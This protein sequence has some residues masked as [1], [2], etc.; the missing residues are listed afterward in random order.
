MYRI[1]IMK[2]TILALTVTGLFS[3]NALSAPS[4]LS[5]FDKI[6]NNPEWGVP[7]QSMYVE[8]NT[9]NYFFLDDIDNKYYP[10]TQNGV[11]KHRP[12]RDAAGLVQY[13][14]QS[15]SIRD[16]KK[17]ASGIRAN[18]KFASAQGKLISLSTNTLLDENT[19]QTKEINGIKSRGEELSEHVKTLTQ[20]HSNL[21]IKV[22]AYSTRVD[23]VLRTKQGEQ[24]IQGEQ[25]KQGIQGEQGIQGIQG[26]RGLTGNRGEQ[27]EQGIQGIAGIQGEK[28]ETGEKGDAFKFSDFTPNDLELLKGGPEGIQGEQGEQG[29]QGER[30]FDGRDGLEISTEYS[31]QVN[32]NGKDD[33]DG[34]KWVIDDEKIK[35]ETNDEASAVS[36]ADI[37]VKDA[38]K[39]LNGI[40]DAE[41]TKEALLAASQNLDK[42]KE[43][44]RAES[45]ALSDKKSELTQR[46]KTEINVQKHIVGKD[47]NKAGN[48]ANGINRNESNIYNNRK[49][50]SG[51][52]TA[53]GKN[54]TAIGKNTTAIGKNTTDI[55]NLR[56]DF[57]RLSKDYYSFKEQTNGAIAGVAAMGQLA[58]PYGVGN[59]SFGAAVGNYNS[60]QA[61]AV[62]M[63]YRYSENVTVRAAAAANSGNNM[64]PILAASIN[65]EW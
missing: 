64:E 61:I 17:L 27:G 24:G 39:A 40:K 65:Y 50:I 30:G 59:F 52:T 33:K 36:E 31:K 19:K 4:D 55:K 7:Y 3:A 28:G 47:D 54:T 25:G 8:E 16:I 60:E 43:R 53:I 34:K 29:I 38:E 62:G 21:D 15:A 37:A 58:Q 56:Q 46:A 51:N 35:D 13:E 1:H 48:I 9:G 32:K 49:A 41:H 12:R 22:D 44:F 18:N 2:K 6:S 5:E 11:D 45:K 14:G 10:M 63:G 42:A 20:S 23:G 57:E 26:E